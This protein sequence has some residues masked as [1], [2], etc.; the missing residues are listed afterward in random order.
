MTS[1]SELFASLSPGEIRDLNGQVITGDVVMNPPKGVTVTNG[2]FSGDTEVHFPEQVTFDDCEILPRLSMLGG[3]GWAV[4]GCKFSGG[5]VKAQL[6]V[7]LES[8]V[9]PSR[10]GCPIN[11]EVEDCVFEEL[12]GQWGQ[13]PQGHH[14]YILTTP[15]IEM[16]GYVRRCTF[17][18]SPYGAPIKLGGTGNFWRSEGIRGVTVEDCEVHSILDGTGSAKTILTQG[19]RTDV[20]VKNCTLHGDQGVSANVQSMDNSI[21]R[22]D[23]CKYPD[24]VNFYARWYLWWFGLFSNESKEARVGRRRNIVMT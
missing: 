14:V 15:R 12:D 7:G 8:S 21:M 23:N 16:N 19:L 6:G 2:T 22:L 5:V 18:G 9:A 1:A 13:Y 20:T 3:A 11:W 24:G 10:G 17:A 4:R